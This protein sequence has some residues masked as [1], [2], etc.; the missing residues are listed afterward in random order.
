L[1]IE[2]YRFILRNKPTEGNCLHNPNKKVITKIYEIY[3]VQKKCAA[4]PTE[5]ESASKRKKK[6]IM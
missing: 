1:I 3:K 6:Y 5:V 4:K 2:K